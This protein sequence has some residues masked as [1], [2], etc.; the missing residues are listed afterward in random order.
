[1]MKDIKVLLNEKTNRE[2]RKKF[3]EIPNENIKN[4]K[5]P[6]FKV[7]KS[8]CVIVECVCYYPENDIIIV[9]GDTSDLNILEEA[10]FTVE[11]PKN[12]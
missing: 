10:G 5:F 2:L 8:R 7:R 12:N 3:P 6:S 9:A 4:G 1:M 11:K